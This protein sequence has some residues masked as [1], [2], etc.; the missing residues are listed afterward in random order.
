MKQ[1]TWLF[2]LLFVK[3]SSAGDGL[4]FIVNAGNG[5]SRLSR[6]ELNNYYL[7]KSRQWADG[8]PV[9]FFDRPDN[10][11]EKKLF[12]SLYLKRSQADVEQY[13]IGQKL[14]SGNT[15]PVEVQSDKVIMNLISRFPGAISFINSDSFK[16]MP[17][18][19]KIEVTE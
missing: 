5:V 1:L 2:I 16:E 10:S 19:K 7:K 8:N 9:R 4:V 12:L 17:G 3:T 13:W 6:A 15:A 11:N 14:Y 18:I